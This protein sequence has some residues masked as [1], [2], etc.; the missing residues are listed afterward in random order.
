MRDIL[1]LRDYLAGMKR[2]AI[3]GKYGLPESRV[4]RIIDKLIY[5]HHYFGSELPDDL[6]AKI[7]ELV[8]ALIDELSTPHD[9]HSLS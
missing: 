6:A 1:I 4:C 5:D 7:K 2:P 8:G 9:P 3:A